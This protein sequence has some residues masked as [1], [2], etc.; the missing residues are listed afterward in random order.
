MV[1]NFAPVDRNFPVRWM[2]ISWGKNSEGGRVGFFVDEHGTQNAVAD[3]TKAYMTKEEAEK[4]AFLAL[5][6]NPTLHGTLTVEEVNV[7]GKRI[8]V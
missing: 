2:V 4:A 8:Q 6:A 5:V 3:F 7:I 1:R